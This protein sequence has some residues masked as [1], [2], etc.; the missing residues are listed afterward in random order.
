MTGDQAILNYVLNQKAMLDGLRVE[1]R[2]IMRWPGRE[3]Q[4]LDAERLSRKAAEP[5]IVHWAGL[6]KARLSQMN[7]SDLLVFFEKLYYH[8]T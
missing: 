3:L 1:C 5:F 4:G 7:G 8:R 2:P 6:K